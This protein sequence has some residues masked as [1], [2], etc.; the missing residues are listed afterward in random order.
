ME[1][2]ILDFK[3]EFKLNLGN[4]KLK[5]EKEYYINGMTARKGWI[6]NACTY[7]DTKNVWSWSIELSND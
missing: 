2:M 4:L 7:G 5:F 3:F 6:I 1:L